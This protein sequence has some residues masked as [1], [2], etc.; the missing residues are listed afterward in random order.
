MQTIRR[1][2]PLTPNRLQIQASALTLALFASCG[3]GGGGGG[4]DSLPVNEGDFAASDFSYANEKPMGYHPLGLD[5]ALLTPRAE[6]LFLMPQGDASGTMPLLEDGPDQGRGLV[7]DFDGLFAD[8][9]ELLAAAAGNVDQDADQELIVLE[10]SFIRRISVY[11]VDR[12]ASGSLQRQFLTFVNSPY[13]VVDARIELAD[14]DGDFLDEL[15]LV[16][17]DLEFERTSLDAWVKVLDDPESQMR[18][19]LSTTRNAAHTSIWALPAD[20]DGD[21]SPELVIALEGDTTQKGRMAVRVYDMAAD[22]S[23]RMDRILN[24]TYLVPSTSYDWSKVTVGDFDGD[25]REDLVTAAFQVDGLSPSMKVD[26]WT[27]NGGGFTGVSDFTTGQL[28]ISQPVFGT[29]WDLAAYRGRPLSSGAEV[30]AVAILYPSGSKYQLRTTRYDPEI[31]NWLHKS[32]PLAFGLLNDAVAIGVADEEADDTE[33]LVLAFASRNG[34]NTTVRRMTYDADLLEARIQPDLVTT[35]DHWPIP[36]PVVVGFDYDGDGMRV[37]ST[38]RRSLSVSSPIPLV[39]LQAPPTKEGISQNHDDSSTSYSLAQSSGQSVGVS[40]QVTASVSVG[41]EAE[42]LFGAFGASAKATVGAGLAFSGETS[43]QTTFVKGYEGSYDS[44]VILFQGTLYESYE[45][46]VVASPEPDLVGAFLTIDLPVEAKT[47]KWTTDFYNQSVG[48]Q[49]HLPTT[50]L[51]H[52]VGDPASYP[53]RTALQTALANAQAWEDE[54]LNTVGQ[55]SGVNAAAILFAEENVQ[56]TEVTVFAELETEFKAGGVTAGASVGIE[57]GHSYSVSYGTETEFFGSVGDIQDTDEYFDWRYD[58]G[59]VVQNYG[60]VIENGEVKN[61]P[62]V[63]PMQV[64]R[65]WVEAN[66]AGYQQP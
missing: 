18:E 8:G 22:G 44:D 6:T 61:Q 10:R 46:E 52:D 41:F 23:Q 64:V 28:P 43:T 45:Y 35:N 54:D 56:Q 50:L 14:V 57:H 58:W 42:D 17:R 51:A 47:Y 65:Y 19:L 20:L 21:Y 62:G 33:E 7:A 38:G 29:E 37:H 59:L 26:L 55:G 66:G 9:A 34:S 31:D 30:D 40:T 48:A 49:Y 24:W 16:G 1:L 36:R 32:V 3:G 5:E 13:D 15:I 12:D 4:G 60:T 39:L 25:G 11:L 2:R 27:W 53:D 63:T